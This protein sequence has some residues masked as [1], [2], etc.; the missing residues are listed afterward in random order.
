MEKFSRD[1]WAKI[2]GGASA[3]MP[4]S[5][6]APT[7]CLESFSPSIACA[8]H[9]QSRHGI[10]DVDRQRRAHRRDPVAQLV[11]LVAAADRD[12]HERAQLEPLG[13]HAA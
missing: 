2:V 11:V 7:A 12:G 3:C 1:A 5:T 8:H 6:S 13:A 9:A 10:L 4:A